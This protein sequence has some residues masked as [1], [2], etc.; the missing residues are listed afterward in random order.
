MSFEFDA[1]GNKIKE[2]DAKGNVYTYTYDTSGNMLTMKDPLN[3][4]TAY[5]YSPVYSQV[6]SVT[7]PKGNVYTMTYDALGNLTQFTVMILMATLLQYRAPMD[8]MQPWQLM[9]G[10]IYCLLPMQGIIHTLPNTIF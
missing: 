3:Q 2:T 7:D 8:T 5:T 10:V 4:V 9:Q 6:T 1:N